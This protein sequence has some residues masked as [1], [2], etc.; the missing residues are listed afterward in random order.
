MTEH[1]RGDDPRRPVEG[2]RGAWGSGPSADDG[3]TRAIGAPSPYAGTPTAGPS[4]GLPYGTAPLTGPYAA[5]AGPPSAGGAA[6]GAGPHGAPPAAAH[7]GRSGGGQYGG[8]QY[9]PGPP[10]GG[11]PHGGTQYGGPPPPPGWGPAPARG[12]RGGT[13]VVALVAVLVLLVGGIGAWWFLLR[14]RGADSPVEAT[15]L[16]A[17]D[18]QEGGLAAGVT[19]LHPDE[20]A[21]AGDLSGL[22]HEELVRLEVLRPDAGRDALLTGTTFQDLRFD[23]AAVEQVRPDVAIAKLV[24]GTVTV[25]RDVGALP[26]T[27]SYKRL[28]YPDGVPPAEAPQVIDIAKVVADQGRPVRIATVQVDGDWYP[29]LT[30]TLADLA[31]TEEGEAWPQ[32]TVA[33]RGAGTAQDAVREAVTALFARDARRLVEM[34]PPHELAVVHDVGPLLVE[35]A[36]APQPGVRLVDLVT[37][38]TETAGGTALT[39]ER[40]VVAE[41]GGEQVTVTR[42]GDCLSV[43]TNGTYASPG[44]PTRFCAQDLADEDGGVLGD[45]D[46]A[47]RDLTVRAA[48][49][50]LALRVVVVE[51]GGQ[52]YVS[53]IRTAAGVGIDVL[54]ALQPADLARIAEA[55]R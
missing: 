37:T 16:L 50:V 35:R 24:A 27:D 34:A 11:A 53:P 7:G 8:A 48:G 20:V 5:P 14:G 25:T 17:E 2:D 19:R 10:P 51:D 30:Y 43:M 44:S 42:S 36:G 39:I 38:P 54:R 40:L 31:L 13:V 46:P 26:L 23:D 29:S 28:A 21:L 45:R 6:Y 3:R 12:R 4:D 18:L 32:G 41:D 15:R 55:S 49:A 22:F 1:D 9:V 47:L 52:Y 33:A